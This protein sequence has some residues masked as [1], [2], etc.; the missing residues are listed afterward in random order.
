MSNQEITEKISQKKKRLELY[1]SREEKM[2]TDG[3]Q[4]Y[5]IGSRNVT[6]YNTELS[7][8]RK[9]IT[10]LEN[11]ISELEGKASG[12]KPRK[13]VGIILRDI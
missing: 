9:A 13:A 8:I 11:E 7:E 12:K 4:S 6:R 10:E 1:L 2:M 5:G 3:V